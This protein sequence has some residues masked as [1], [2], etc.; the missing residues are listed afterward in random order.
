MKTKPNIRESFYHTN[1]TNKTLNYIKWMTKNVTLS[2]VKH[3]LKY[4]VERT[5]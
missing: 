2:P 3:W 4:I 5:G 1:S